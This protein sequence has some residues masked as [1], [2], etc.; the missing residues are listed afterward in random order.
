M[1]EY[2]SRFT[3]YDI[4]GYL[5][6]GA[7]G[8]C[9]IAILLSVL[10]PAWAIPEPNGGGRWAVLVI[11][12]YF[13]GHALQGVSYRLFP[14][15]KLRGAIAR[16]CS[17]AVDRI[18]TKAL[19]RHSIEATE[20]AERFAALD[21]LKVDFPDRE[22]FVARQGF[23]R[24]A[25]L[26]FALLCVVLAVAAI[27]ARAVL[28]FGV[29][30]DRPQSAI[31]AIAAAGLCILFRTRYR[32]FLQHELEFAAAAGAAATAERSSSR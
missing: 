10:N 13:I 19:E 22:V 28:L 24:G 14:R 16:D 29:S 6:P 27:L 4:V 23:F 21:A 15:A 26:A 2:L 7:L 9:A 18:A 30:I 17:A 12:A 8:L 11:A 3:F 20:K 1:G 5:L 31:A 25:A 32:D